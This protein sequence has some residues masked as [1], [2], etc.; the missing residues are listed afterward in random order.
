MLGR[1]E[2][3]VAALVL[4]LLQ[5]LIHISAYHQTTEFLGPRSSLTYSNVL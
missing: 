1:V 5:E 3:L 4:R 2:P